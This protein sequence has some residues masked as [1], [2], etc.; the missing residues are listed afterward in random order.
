MLI[1]VNTG[2]FW[3]SAYKDYDNVLVMVEMD[4]FIQ[5]ILFSVHIT[6]LLL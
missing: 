1:L 4:Y 3:I 5:Q 6:L 2:I